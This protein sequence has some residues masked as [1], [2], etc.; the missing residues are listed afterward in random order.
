MEY[1]EFIEELRFLVEKKAGDSASVKLHRITKNNDVILDAIIM[2]RKGEYISPTIYLQGFYEDYLDGR[3]LDEIADQI[4][5]MDSNNRFEPGVCVSELFNFEFI[6]DRIIFKIVNTEKNLTMLDGVPHR[7]FLDLSIIYICYLDMIGSGYA[8]TV[9]LN[10]HIS[11]WDVNEEE[12]YDIAINNTCKICE[13]VI[14]SMNEIMIEMLMADDFSPEHKTEILNT[15][16]SDDKMC[17]MYILT[18]KQKLNGA[19]NIIYKDI[20]IQFGKENGNFYILPSS[21][22]ELIL[23]PVYENLQEKQLLEMVREVNR[24]EVSDD[25]FLSDNIYYFDTVQN[26]LVLIGSLDNYTL[27]H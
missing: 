14:K 16:E 1:I 2:E 22:H 20:R 18:N 24:T 9:I 8:T 19:A 5:E 15:L 6:R 21:V 4:I 3:E 11:E 25:E 13:P 12:L 7:D 23:I 17:P 26:E 27:T 10:E